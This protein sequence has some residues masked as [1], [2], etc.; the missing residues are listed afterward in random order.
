TP[1]LQ[2]GAFAAQPHTLENFA[3]KK[4]GAESDACPAGQLGGARFSFAKGAPCDAL[5]TENARRPRHP[6]EGN[7]SAALVRT[8]INSVIKQQ[9]ERAFGF[10][11][12]AGPLLQFS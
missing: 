1:D 12:E 3:I 10:D 7:A 2:S 9:K 4:R 6:N 5:S 11:R 8:K